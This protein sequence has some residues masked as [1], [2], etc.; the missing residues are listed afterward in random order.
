MGCQLGVGTYGNSNVQMQVTPKKSFDTPGSRSPITPMSQ[1]S[2]SP[3]MDDVGAGGR[4]IPN[5][6]SS[7]LLNAFDRCEDSEPPT[8]MSLDCENSSAFS[9]LL[10]SQLF[11]SDLTNAPLSKSVYRYKGC[12]QSAQWVNKE[13]VHCAVIEGVGEAQGEK[14]GVET[15]QLPKAPYKVLDAPQLPDDFYLNLMDWSQKDV[16]AV[17]LGS[18]VYLWSATTSSVTCLLDLPQASISS[19]SWTRGGDHLA[20]GDS[21]G[22]VMIYDA[23][24]GSLVREMDGHRARVG[25][26]AWN[27]DL[28]STGSK[29]RL[30]LHRDVRAREDHISRLLGHKQEVCGLKWSPDSQQLASGGNDNKVNI[31]SLH[32]HNPVHHFDDHTAAVKAIA[33]S[34]HQYGLLASG[35]GTA[36]RCIRFWNTFSGTRVGKVDTGSQVCNLV[37]SRNSN[38]LASTHG[39]S[40]NQIMIWKYPGMQKVGELMG[41]TSRVLYLSM[42]AD[43]QSIVTGA[44]DETLRFWRVFPAKGKSEEG[45][46]FAINFGEMR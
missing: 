30:I 1:Q 21:A 38:E 3:R 25:T 2:L 20:V 22:K 4:F 7:N 28:L 44:G 29:D 24:Q 26:M 36:D 39:Y 8:S 5:R 15:R 33:W 35:G 43:G 17:G 6:L 9:H 14:T 40:L 19:L 11:G 34:P 12:S 46:K 31:W 45:S 13:N 41:H 16:L 18:S 42:S 32:S 23:E 10:H 37:F 27:E